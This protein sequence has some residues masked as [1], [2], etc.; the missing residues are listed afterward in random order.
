MKGFKKNLHLSTRIDKQRVYKWIE[1]YPKKYGYPAP[2]YL[3]FAR[4]LLEDGWKVRQYKGGKRGISKYLFIE[5]GDHL[6][7]IRFSNHKPIKAKEEESD[8]DFYVGVSHFQTSTTEE[9]RDQVQAL[10]ENNV[11]ITA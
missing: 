7:K 9:I 8:C 2:K 11:C 5:K 3:L 6:Y 4:D 10:Y 1:K